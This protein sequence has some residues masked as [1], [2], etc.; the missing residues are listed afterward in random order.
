MLF[1]VFDRYRDGWIIEASDGMKGVR[2][3]DDYQ[4]CIDLY[5]MGPAPG[6]MSS[7]RKACAVLPS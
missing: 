2:Y 1:F 6:S 5:R 3:V 7:S 4:R